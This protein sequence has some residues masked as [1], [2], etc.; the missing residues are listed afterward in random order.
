MKFSLSSFLVPAKPI[1]EWT[2]SSSAAVLEPI[3]DASVLFNINLKRYI[4]KPTLILI[5]GENCL[6][7]NEFVKT[8]LGG[9]NG[10]EDRFGKFWKEG[11]SFKENVLAILRNYYKR[12][13]FTWRYN[14]GSIDSLI[15]R[16]ESS[17]LTDRLSSDIVEE[18]YKHQVS[19]FRFSSSSTT[20]ARLKYI[21]LHC[22]GL[23]TPSLRAEVQK[24]LLKKEEL[25]DR[26]T[27]DLMA[28]MTALSARRPSRGL[29]F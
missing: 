8:Q 1:V 20:S 6:N 18:L 15:K 9:V 14:R 27:K 24:K 3:P 21:L 4:A 23:Y 12:K 13:M 5:N 28:E 25:S 17:A 29:I 22:S 11:R 10:L 7:A 2:T 26:K 16:I 19:S